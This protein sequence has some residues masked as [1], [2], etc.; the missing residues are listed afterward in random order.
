MFSGKQKL[1]F[2]ENQNV[3][4]YY[5][6]DKKANELFAHSYSHLFKLPSTGLRFFTVYGPWGVLICTVQ[7]YGCYFQRATNKHLQQRFYEA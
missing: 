7:I 3:I 6:H 2:A 4:Q 5:L 1:L